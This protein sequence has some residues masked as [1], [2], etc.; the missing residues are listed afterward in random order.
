MR[1]ALLY[2]KL[3]FDIE[4]CPPELRGQEEVDD[5][6]SVRDAMVSMGHDVT[7]VL[8]DSR[9]YRTLA[10]GTFDAVFNLCDNIEDRAYSEPC[11]TALLEML[12]IPFTGSGMVAI[13]SCMDKART[14]AIL[15]VHGI[16]TPGFAVFER[17]DQ[18]FNGT[19]RY[20]LIA[21]PV[22]ED[23]S[24]GISNESVVDTEQ[25]LRERLEVLLRLYGEPVLVEE[26]IDGRELAVAV[27]GRPGEVLAVSEI[28]FDGL[29]EGAP[30]ICSYRAKWEPGSAL[31]RH[32]VPR[33]PAQLEPAD[34]EEVRRVGLESYR[35]LGCAGYGRVDLRMDGGV[36][37][38]LEVNPNPDIS[39]DAGFFRAARVAGMSYEGMIERIVREAVAKT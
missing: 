35:L 9:A 21:K 1:V 19:L 11:V 29:P 25:A 13:G 3:P 33:C 36:P 24:E 32:T 17:A 7:V 28:L 39:V 26:F 18:D 22:F 14:K 23:A 20:P 4:D 15:S 38:V 30:R 27:I 16:P 6:F 5:L 8:F 37:Y 12:G 2:R 31:Y 34:E 10:E